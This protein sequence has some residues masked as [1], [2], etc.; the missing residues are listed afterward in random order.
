MA[1]TQFVRANPQLLV[2]TGA[3][4]SLASGIPTYRDREGRWRHSEPIKHQEFLQ[5]P[6]RRRRYWARSMRGW[7]AVRDASPNNAHH[8]LASLERAGYVRSVI[9]Q[10]VDRLHQ[11]AGSR[12]VIDLHGRLDR[13]ICLSCGGHLC[14][15][16]LQEELTRLN[17]TNTGSISATPRPDGD[18]DLPD[19][20][21]ES[22]QVPNC[23]ECN[24]VLMPDV[25]FFGG[26]VPRPRVNTCMQA[27]E[28]ADALLAIGSSLQVFSGF[29]F[30]RRAE[31]LGK[32]LAIV[33]PGDTRAD[34]M[35]D[36]KISQDCGAVL[37]GIAR[38][39]I[40]TSAGDNPNYR[41]AGV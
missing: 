19:A 37:E 9:T 15:N 21:V 39:L 7:P 25:V 30:C 8:A 22:T 26:T 13:V 36:L 10:N 5:D 24:G 20:I 3:G 2:L 17:T 16:Q 14:R 18:V 1:L 6:D 34:A 32:P 4:I 27:L 29:R 28:E 12:Q 41:D 31:Q 38:E 40:R 35:A 33:N 11:R 23:K